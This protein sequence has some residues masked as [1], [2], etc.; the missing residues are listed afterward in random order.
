M[1]LFFRGGGDMRLDRSMEVDVDENIVR[2]RLISYFTFSGYTQAITQPHLMSFHRGSTIAFTPKGWKVNAI[3]QIAASPGQPTHVTA[4]YD[5]DTTGQFVI[6]SEVRFWENEL[7][8]VEQAVRTG[9]VDFIARDKKSQSLLRTSMI[10]SVLFL[11]LIA[12]V[13]IAL[14]ALVAY[15]LV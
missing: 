12:I 2:E 3:V 5:I 8:D 14:I 4:T 15:L 6:K 9:K 10:G 13:T 7:E 1:R 11:G